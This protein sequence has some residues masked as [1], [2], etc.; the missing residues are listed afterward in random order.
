MRKGHKPPTAQ[1]RSRLVREYQGAMAAPLT[2]PSDWHRRLL[3]PCPERPCGRA[4]ECSDEFAPSNA[5][6]HLTLPCESPSGSSRRPRVNRRPAPRSRPTS[7]GRRRRAGAWEAAGASHAMRVTT[8]RDKGCGGDR[9]GPGPVSA[10]GQD[11]LASTPCRRAD[12]GGRARQR[13]G[14]LRS[15]A[16]L[17]ACTAVTLRL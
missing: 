16:A 11:W 15:L 7:A 8:F 13:T 4:T 12:G 17:A 3:R 6:P 5:N 10:G 14:T 9:D 1:A 2:N